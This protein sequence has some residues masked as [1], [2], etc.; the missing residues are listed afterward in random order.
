MDVSA[1]EGSEIVLE[2]VVY[3]KPTPTITW[4]KDGLKLFLENRMLQ[5][6]DRKGYYFILTAIKS[7]S[8]NA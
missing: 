2:C 5:Y 8:Q 1:I 6:T 3:G 4:Y 7:C